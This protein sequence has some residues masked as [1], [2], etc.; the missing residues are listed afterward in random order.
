VL[1]A[2]DQATSYFLE[3]H[4]GALLLTANQSSS[5]YSSITFRYTPLR[6]FFLSA[7]IDWLGRVRDRI[8]LIS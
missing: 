2:Q 4:K 6:T 8:F 7:A 5:I 1:L 3:F